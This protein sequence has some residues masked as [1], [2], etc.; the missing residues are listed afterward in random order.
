M[1]N[2]KQTKLVK[3]EMEKLSTS[4]EDKEVCCKEMA[5]TLQ[6]LK[7]QLADFQHQ[8]ASKTESNELLR[9]RVVLRNI[10]ILSKK[11]HWW[12]TK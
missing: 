3:Q 11:H 6:Q 5:D 10:L 8:V 7:D 4:V 1:R 12:L 9:K 2:I